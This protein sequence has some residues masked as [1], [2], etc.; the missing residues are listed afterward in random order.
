MAEIIT[1]RLK[2]LTLKDLSEIAQLTPVA[3]QASA[4]K[5]G[6]IA[7]RGM[8]LTVTG[9]EEYFKRNKLALLLLV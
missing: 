4:L 6:D 9:I 2:Q 8:K 1:H 7:I 3:R 5:E